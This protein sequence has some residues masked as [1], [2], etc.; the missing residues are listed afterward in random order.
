[1]STMV[2]FDAPCAGTADFQQIAPA[3][4]KCDNYVKEIILYLSFIFKVT[5][6]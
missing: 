2:N 1:M 6:R 3:K 4:R 5:L